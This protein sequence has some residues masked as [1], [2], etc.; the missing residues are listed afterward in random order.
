M[1]VDTDGLGLGQTITAFGTPPDF[2][3]PWIEA[4]VVQVCVG[5]D[6]ARFLELYETTLSR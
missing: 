3:E 6:G 5:V 2:W 4:P 1:R